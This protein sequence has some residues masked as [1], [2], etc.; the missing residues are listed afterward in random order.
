MSDKIEISLEDG[1]YLYTY[2]EGIQI[3][4][5]YREPWRN[6]TGDNF[7]LAMARRIQD[8]EEALYKEKETSALLVLISE[9][10]KSKTYTKEELFAKIEEDRYGKVP[11][12]GA[13]PIIF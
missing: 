7:I 10:K 9:A 8:L 13:G 11:C 1:K 12:S 3:V 2:R 6:E 5:R 4:E